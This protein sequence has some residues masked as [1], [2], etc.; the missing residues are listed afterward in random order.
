MP[1]IDVNILYYLNEHLYDDLVS[2]TI[3]CVRKNPKLI[4]AYWY[5]GMAYLFQNQESKAFTIWILPLVNHDSIPFTT[6]MDNFL[7]DVQ[8]IRSFGRNSNLLDQAGVISDYLDLIEEVE[9]QKI[10]INLLLHY[11]QPPIEKSIVVHKFISDAI[12]QGKWNK[13]ESIFD[14]YK[15]ILRETIDSDQN[16]NEKYLRNRLNLLPQPLLYFYDDPQQIRPIINQISQLSQEVVRKNYSC[17]AKFNCP[18]L[19]K[20]KKLKIGYIGHTLRRHS[21]GL[22]SRWLIKHH[23]RQKF[24]I[25]IYLVDNQHEDQITDQFFKNNVEKC[26][27][28]NNYLND[29]VTEIEKDEID[30]LIDLDSFT[31]TL[32]SLVMALKPAPIQVSWLGM[33]S[34]GVPSI[35]YFIADPY[36]LPEEAQ[37]YYQEKIW[38]LPNSYLA[39]D[40]FEISTSNTTRKELEIPDDSIIYL[41]VQNALKRYPQTIL[42]QIKILKLVPNSFLVIK[43]SGDQAALK[44]LFENISIQEGLDINRLRFLPWTPTE[45]MHRANLQ[46]ADVVLDTYPYNGATTTLETLWVDI[47]LVTR[48]GKQFAARNSYTFMINAGITEGIAWTDEEYVEWGIRLGTDENLRKQISW[49]LRQ[50]KKT[51][52]LWNGKKFAR[53]MED[54]YRQM[55]EI[56]VNAQRK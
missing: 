7:K 18:H 21:V 52:P 3:D 41:N 30:I 10:L 48:V 23:N 24:S 49:K 33:D 36:V 26:F 25:Y 2:Y 8:S 22:L 35:D 31:H 12:N 50:S 20:R 1:S 4:Y 42:L 46:L 27:N 53:D 28:S 32:T 54:A 40:G 14:F 9:L 17:P 56:Y 13:V 44:L 51:S 37:T 19:K 34:N 55:W 5:L 29:F 47:P 15:Q 16:L 38:R 43:G 39:V 11:Q 45:E 6:E